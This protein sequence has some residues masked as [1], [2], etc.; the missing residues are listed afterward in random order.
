MIFAA[1][2]GTRMGPLTA[3]CP[4]P[5]LPVAGLTLLDRTLDLVRSAGCRSVVVNT[6]YLA[7]QIERHVRASGA[8][9][10]TIAREKEALLDTGGGL[11]AAATHFQG[12]A[13]FTIN[14]DAIW[15]GGH[16]LDALR[17]AWN[18][19]RMDALV[20]LAPADAVGRSVSDFRLDEVGG[21]ARADG[22]EGQVYLGAQIIR[23]SVVAEHGGN[24]F[25]LNEIWDQLIARGRLFGTVFDGEWMDVGTEEA[26]ERAERQ[27]R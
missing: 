25:S 16:P 20:L 8:S 3:N 9:D 7:E 6:Y 17:G 15:I 13:I 22:R 26:L 14:P 4:K 11:K 12:E 27:L 19:D 24:V 1:G 23:P 21:V 5:L 2:L 18:A 10:V